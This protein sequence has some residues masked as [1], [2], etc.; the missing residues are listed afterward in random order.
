MPS[1]V[2]GLGRRN[3]HRDSPA[4]RSSLG[5]ATAFLPRA[6][7]HA[8]AILLLGVLASGQAPAP[9]P[10]PPVRHRAP[11]LAFM[12]QS[13]YPKGRPGWVVD[14]IVPLCAGGLDAPENM[15][16]QVAAESYVKDKYERQMCKA[17]EKQ[18]M[19]VQVVVP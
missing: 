3:G 4:L 8:A 13:G 15:Q 17:L 12:K 10:A 9:R 2:S 7:G 14:H 5:T 1:W 16:W 19:R 18:H 6:A 11:I